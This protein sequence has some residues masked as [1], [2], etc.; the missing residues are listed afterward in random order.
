MD[1]RSGCLSVLAGRASGP[2]L[3]RTLRS[4]ISGIGESKVRDPAELALFQFDDVQF[5][6][7]RNGHA[8]Y[9]QSISI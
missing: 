4:E 2:A 1:E 9:T 8:A 7:S 6:K 3:G 5:I